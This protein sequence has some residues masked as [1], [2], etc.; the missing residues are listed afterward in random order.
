MRRVVVC[1][2]LLATALAPPR[3]EAQPDPSPHR[4]ASVSV[5]GVRIEYLD[6]GG[7]G[8]A[9][10]FFPG[11]G[12]SAHVFDGFAPRFTDRHRVVGVSRV[13][14]GGSDQP[15]RLGY[16]LA[17][18]VEQLR[19][20]LEALGL[21]RAVLAGHSLGGDEITAFATRYP[22]RTAG[23]IYL[24]AALD[25]VGA[26]KVE[27]ALA[28]LFAYAPAPTPAELAGAA[29]YRR[30][31]RRTT[32]VEFPLGEVL[33]TTRFDASGVVRGAR[34]PARVA[35]AIAG[36]IARLDYTGVRAPALA[37]YAD[38]TRADVLP[39]LAADRAANARAAALLDSVRPWEAGERA[40]FARE[41][42]RARVVA[43]PSHHY[44]F[45][46]HPAATERLMRA[47][48]TTIPPAAR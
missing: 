45:L 9:L 34:T 11:F 7:S 15:E 1:A 13:G 18:R 38:K 25:H 41:L 4:S 27:A 14:Y 8:P 35:R 39:F 26:L 12:N 32:G 10:V 42:P 31:L 29:A 40:R 43:F 24:D 36:Q 37:L 20:V 16:T 19:A 3:L 46:S 6:W 47:F 48:L 44:Q 28:P 2:A 30:F 21:R 5:D 33:A 17:A 23:L 22:E